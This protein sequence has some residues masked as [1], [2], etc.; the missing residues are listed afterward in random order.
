MNSTD[1][2]LLQDR[3]STIYSNYLD[4]VQP[5][6]IDIE[7]VTGKFPT[8]I[9]NEIRSIFAHLARANQC[10]ESDPALADENCI[11]AERHMKRAIFDCYKTLCFAYFERVKQFHHDYA[12]VDLH[13]AENGKFLDG[14]NKREVA[15][16][17]A[18]MKARKAEANGLR[19]SDNE[20]FEYYEDAY[21]SYESL[22]SYIDD[23]TE[24]L[25]FAASA[26][27]KTKKSARWGLIFGVVSALLAVVSIIEGIVIATIS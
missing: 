13:L 3:V 9:L 1:Q 8:Q 7:V 14:F 6:L 5:L 21:S 10:E 22:S 4:V 20:I 16:K 11:K 2:P 19:F 17:N 24:A 27:D 25:N 26:T 23:S 15:A 18:F 12:N